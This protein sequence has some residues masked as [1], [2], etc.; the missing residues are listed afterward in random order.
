MSGRR[1][2]AYTSIAVFAASSLVGVVVAPS[3][4]RTFWTSRIFDNSRVG[5][6]AYVSNQSLN[7]MLRRALESGA[8]T[9]LL[10]LGLAAAVVVFGLRKAALAS[11]GSQEILGISLAA[12]VGM[13][14]SPVS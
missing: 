12:L 8:A 9:Q 14:V 6:N 10:W 7:G 3:D 13:I 4:S 5:N 2:S 11:R 1:R